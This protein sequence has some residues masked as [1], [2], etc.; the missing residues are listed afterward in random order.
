M[1]LIRIFFF[2]LGLSFR[3]EAL[4]IYR[5]GNLQDVVT[6]TEQVNCLAGGGDDNLWVDG[7]KYLLRSSGG[8]DVVIVR[9][10]GESGGYESWI[11]DDSENQGLPKVNSVTVLSVEN[12]LDANDPR[13]ANVLRHAELIFFSGGDQNLYITWFRKTA[14]EYEVYRAIRR[15]Q[16]PVG[17][18]SA[19][20]ALLA[21]IDYRARYDS[22]STGGMVTSEDVLNDPTADFVDLDSRVIIGPDLGRIITDTHF[23]QRDRH[24][25]ML[26][27]L[28]KALVDENLNPAALHGIAADEG[29]AF[30][31]NS[32]GIGRVYGPGAVY[33]FA[34]QSRPEVLKSGKP[35]TWSKD[36]GGVRVDVLS[37][38][39]YLFDLKTWSTQRDQNQRKI[40]DPH[41]SQVWWVQ[42][43]RHFESSF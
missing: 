11:Y 32:D 24:G 3:V 21:G 34:P 38:N 36:S 30:C 5:T 8:G 35:L 16:V 37:Q 1:N 25:R 43:G 4:S 39:N 41:Q 17:G 28:A 15:R 22:P 26:G 19:G 40:G 2:F 20:M 42:Q 18:T 14:L 31:Y 10:G 33:F 29:S 27:F 13:L 23:S 9:T 6:K 12:R 7:W